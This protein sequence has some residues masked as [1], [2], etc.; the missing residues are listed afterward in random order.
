MSNHTTYETKSKIRRITSAL[1]RVGS[2]STAISK[3]LV[4]LNQ[5]LDHK[6]IDFGESS[7]GKHDVMLA[8]PKTICGHWKIMTASFLCGAHFKEG[9]PRRYV[10]RCH[11]ILG[12][13]ER[14]A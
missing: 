5:P 7:N 2:G 10:K 11:Q 9:R 14:S 3:I 12:V 8:L 6:L 4:L 13:E 1:D